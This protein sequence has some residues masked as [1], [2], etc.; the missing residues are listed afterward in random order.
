M[1]LV[2]QNPA[3][4]QL[5]LWPR[6]KLVVEYRLSLGTRNNPVLEK[7][8]LLSLWSPV[9]KQIQFQHREWSQPAR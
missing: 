5:S 4:L 6:L 7:P 3:L 9:G 1:R 2:L 8:N